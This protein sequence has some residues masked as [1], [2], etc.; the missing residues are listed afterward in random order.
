MYLKC[1]HPDCTS[2]FDYTQ[3][4]LFRFRQTP[5]HEKQ[6]AHWHGVKHF[7]LCARC[8]NSFTIEYQCGMGILLLQRLEAISGGQPCYCVLQAEIAPKAASP[9]RAA[10]S[11]TRRRQVKVYLD[12]V[13]LSAIEILET[14]NV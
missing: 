6:P 12:P 4:R 5:R 1:A 2:D 7:W 8:C 3:G 11:S 13:A 14:R 10:R 9:V